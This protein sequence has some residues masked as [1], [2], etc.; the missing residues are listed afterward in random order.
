MLVSERSSIQLAFSRKIT[1]M[2][3]VSSTKKHPASLK[4]LYLEND[5]QLYTSLGIAS[6]SETVCW[7]V[8][9]IKGRHP[10]SLVSYPKCDIFWVF[11]GPSRCTLSRRKAPQDVSIWVCL[12]IRDPPKS[13]GH[14]EVFFRKLPVF[15]GRFNYWAIAHVIISF[16]RTVS[17]FYTPED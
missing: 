2:R 17:A 13:A 4:R 7:R 9:K 3:T 6:L 10:N 5:L 12:K 15:G 8:S 16:R 1:N 14:G 11:E